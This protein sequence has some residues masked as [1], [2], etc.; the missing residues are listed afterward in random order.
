[1][2]Q[3][4]KN[5]FFEMINSIDKPLAR[6]T[7]KKRENTNYSDPKWKRDINIDPMDFKRII[8][9]CYEQTYVHTSIN[10]D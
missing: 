1:M 10:L 5:E 4:K 2:L 6:L 9:E 7:K 8:K 3:F